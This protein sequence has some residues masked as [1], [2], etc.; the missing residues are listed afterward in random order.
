MTNYTNH[1]TNSKRNHE[2]KIKEKQN[3][4]LITPC[5]AGLIEANR[6]K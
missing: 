6:Y 4:S 3:L 5:V 1:V 2:Q